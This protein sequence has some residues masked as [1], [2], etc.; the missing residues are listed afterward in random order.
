[1]GP[2]CAAMGVS[3]LA[4]ADTELSSPSASAATD[5]A[6]ADGVTEMVASRTQRMSYLASESG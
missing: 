4:F 6:S 2:P 5:R 3:L 1:M